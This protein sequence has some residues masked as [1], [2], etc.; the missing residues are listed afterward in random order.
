M[1]EKVWDINSY[2]LAYACI[3]NIQCIWI[4][5]EGVGGG[6]ER[7]REREKLPG[8]QK[9]KFRILI[10]ATTHIHVCNVSGHIAY[11]Y[12]RGSSY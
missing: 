6:G 9:K 7:E 8:L 12:V 11:R 10:A 1:Q 3:H 5:T 2:Y 4:E